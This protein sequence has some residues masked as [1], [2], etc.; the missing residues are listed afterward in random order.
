MLSLKPIPLHQKAPPIGLNPMR[1]ALH[2][3]LI[4]SHWMKS[5]ET[6]RM[7]TDLLLTPPFCWILSNET[8]DAWIE[9]LY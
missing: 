7:D 5:N 4:V 3:R 8:N 1:G 2:V 6:N 9:L